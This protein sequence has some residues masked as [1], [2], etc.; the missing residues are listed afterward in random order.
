MKDVD[1]HSL[2]HTS[3][4]VKLVVTNGDIKSVQGDNGHAQAKMVTD[5]YA[6]IDDRRRQKNAVLFDKQFFLD[7]SPSDLS[8]TQLEN[9]ILSL[10]QLPNIKEKILHTMAESMVVSH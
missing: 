3:T 6:E 2:R 4:S 9:L 10:M 7:E 8:E 1:F 5:T